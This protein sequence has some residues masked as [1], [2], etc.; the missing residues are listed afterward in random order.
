MNVGGV[1]RPRHPQQTPSY[2]LVERFYAEFEAVYEERYQ[3]RY[4][5]WRP[6]IG[7]VVRKFLECGDLK[8]GF[9][10]VRC[11]KCRKEFFVPYS[12]RGRC[13]CPSC[14]Q[15]RAL[16]FAEHVDED[17]L[18][19]VP[20]RQHVVTIPKMLRLSFKYDRRLLGELSRCYYDSI[21]EIFL[22]AAVQVPCCAADSP[23]LPAMIASIQ[24]YGDDPTRFHPHLHCL[25]PDGLVLPDGAFLPIPP[26][27]PVQIMLLFRHKLL[28]TLLAEEKI[29][30]RLVDILLSWRHPG[31]SVFQGEPVAPGDHEARER[32]A[33]YCVHPPIALHRLHYDRQTHRVTYDPKNHDRSAGPDCAALRSC[34]A[35]DFLAAL[36][37]HIPDAGQQLIRY[38]G[39]WSHVRRA[40]ARQSCP[41]PAQPAPSPD[42]QDHAQCQRR[43]WARLIKK[44]YEADPLLCPR[45]GR[46]LKLVSLIDDCDVIERILRHLKLWDRPERA[47]PPPKT[48]HYDFDLDAAENSGR[49]ADWSE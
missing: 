34:S 40:R 28:K 42:A 21:K 32:L 2:Q 19:E 45:C 4:G 7:T 8:H 1:Y 49:R 13:F 27:D 10:R 38:Y 24:T 44:V 6:V 43:S 30:Q 26:P 35:L 12:C 31:F 25:L 41:S 23:V 16:L 46:P 5:F 18:G 20:I 36:C 39:E 9:A 11:P 37:I 22:D 29:T 33:R 3:E 48:R 14:H 17:V 15:K 47:P